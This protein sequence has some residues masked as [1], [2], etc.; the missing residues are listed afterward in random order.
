MKTIERVIFQG[1]ICIKRV[2]TVPKKF[3]RKEP[4]GPTVLAHSETGHHHQIDDCGVVM[5][6]EPKNEL[7]A[8]LMLESVE[9]ADV[10]HKRSWDQH[11][12]VR[13][14]GGTGSIFKVTRQREYSPAGWRRVQD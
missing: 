11:E 10:V 2:R 4:D 1:D 6:E 14:D 9:Y 3:K 7:V 12:T 5:F 8:Y 13:L